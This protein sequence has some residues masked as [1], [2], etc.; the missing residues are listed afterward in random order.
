LSTPSHSRFSESPWAGGGQRT[1]RQPALRLHLP[2]GALVDRTEVEKL[3][4]AGREVGRG[5]AEEAHCLATPM[6]RG[7]VG[8]PTRQLQEMYE[9][10]LEVA[11]DRSELRLAHVFDFLDQIRPVQTVDLLAA[12]RPTQQIGLLLRPSEHVILVKRF[13]HK[14]PAG[15]NFRPLLATIM[16][17]ARLFH[18]PV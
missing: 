7:I 8:R 17:A 18:P 10:V 2:E 13:G 16:P 5:L 1:H 3:A 14:D 15:K 12:R 6:R 9:R 4:H 11:P